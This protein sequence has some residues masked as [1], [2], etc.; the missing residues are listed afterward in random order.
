[1]TYLFLS[2]YADVRPPLDDRC[3]RQ[4]RILATA[5][6]LAIN[7]ITIV[8]PAAGGWITLRPNSVRAPRRQARQPAGARRSSNPSCL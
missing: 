3:Y 7:V 2:G 1:M 4:F 6:S 5:A 8:E